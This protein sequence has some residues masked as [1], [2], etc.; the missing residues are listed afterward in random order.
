MNKEKILLEG[1]ENDPKLEIQDD[2]ENRKI[3]K[4]SWEITCEKIVFIFLFFYR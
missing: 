4:E 3:K 1:F 2:N